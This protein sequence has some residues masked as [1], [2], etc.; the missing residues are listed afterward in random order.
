MEAGQAVKV[1]PACYSET[2]G[3]Q[4]AYTG[5]TAVGKTAAGDQSR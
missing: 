3:G 1:C 4:L 5:V 2:A